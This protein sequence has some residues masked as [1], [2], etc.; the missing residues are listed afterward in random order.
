LAINVKEQGIE[1]S[2][3]A[4]L[5]DQLTQAGAARVQEMITNS[6]AEEL[7][8][9]FKR[10]ADNGNGP[11]L[12]DH[13]RS[14]L[15]K[16]VSGFGNS[17]GGVVIWGVDCRS[18]P[19]R[20]DVPNNSYPIAN[21]TRF[22]SWL[23]QAV[24][25]LT[26][27]AHDGVRHLSLQL[28][29]TTGFVA[30]LIPRGHHAPYQTV[31]ESRYLMRAGSSFVPVPHGV[32]AGM[33]G[34]TPQPEIT[35]QY[36]LAP[37]QATSDGKVRFKVE[38]AIRNI[39]MGVAKDTFFNLYCSSDGGGGCKV[40]FENPDEAWDHSLA[41]GVMWNSL[42]KS[43]RRLAPDAMTTPVALFVQLGQP[44][45]KKLKITLSGGATG[46]K[47]FR[48]VLEVGQ[49]ELSAMLDDATSA[50]GDDRKEKL[51]ALVDRVFIG[52]DHP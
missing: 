13:D 43:D 14:N 39:G 12:H 46:S 24:S 25:G 21:P 48:T 32:L 52:L 42:M 2:R 16:S 40:T 18:D 29:Q 35:L 28:D 30:T 4:D 6:E 36:I 3:A 15:A 47:P 8:L 22:K 10:S 31:R 20:G 41:L 9:D 7:F 11:R 33:F 17:E 19:Q 37:A 23:E 5:F 44:V 45:E 38:M 50:K 1:M 49:G 51:K 27:P 34:R 26:V